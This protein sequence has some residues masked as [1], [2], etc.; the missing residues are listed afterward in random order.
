MYKALLLPAIGLMNRLSYLYKFLLISILF[1]IPLLAL[2]Y[3]QLESLS[4]E[5][6]VT[7]IELQAM[8]SLRNSLAMTQIAAAKRD[9]SVVQ[10]NEQFFQQQIKDHYEVYLEKLDAVELAAESLEDSGKLKKAVIDIRTLAVPDS[11]F[12]SEDIALVFDRENQLV[13]E[14]WNLVRSFSYLTGLYQDID[15][16]NFMLMKTVLDSMEPLLEHQGQLRSY[17]AKVVKVGFL[18]SSMMEVMNRLLDTLV[19]DQ[20]RLEAN[21]RPLLVMEN[22]YDKE[23]IKLMESIVQHYKNSIDRLANNLLLDENFNQDWLQYYQQES[24]TI[25]VI[26]DF[27][28]H[29]QALV[30]KRLQSR[31]NE[32]SNYLYTILFGIIFTILITNYLML[33]FNFSVRHSIKAILIAAES[34]AQ[35]DLTT[36]VTINTE[37]ELGR[38]ASEFNSMTYKMQKLLIQVTATV[39]LVASQAVVVD[40]IAQ[41]SSADVD[42]QRLQTDQVAN[43]IHHMVNSAQKVADETLIASKESGEVD[44]KAI[45]GQQLVKT[46]LSDIDQLFKD[47]GHSMSAIDCLVKDSESITKVLDVIKGVAEKTNLLALNAAI[48]A[49][50]AGDQGRGFAVVAD[51]VRTLSKKTQ[52]S[53]T[54]IE[55]MISRLQSGVNNAVKAMEVSYNKVEQT[56]TNSSEVGRTL[57]HISGAITCIADVN[58]QV[59]LVSKEQKTLVNDIEINVQSIMQV[60]NLTAVGAKETVAACRLMVNQIDQ[61]KGMIETFKL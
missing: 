36:Q 26:Y 59:S 45:Y 24:L 18:D 12:Q 38:L 14:S 5:Q 22:V 61:L 30:E 51:E 21:I 44:K 35:G 6:Q 8:V 13:L 28:N 19:N 58:A 2:A 17:S 27:I 31:Y 55:L 7:K 25:E 60:G 32:Q 50:R 54:E 47:I 49:A 3:L 52:Q 11:A 33:G 9:M 16:H 37:D 42:K 15:Q 20:K 34:V 43:A 46:T 29:A 10:D 39:N 53:T 1:L 4:T 56:V 48:E 40:S 57:E 23:L 41:K